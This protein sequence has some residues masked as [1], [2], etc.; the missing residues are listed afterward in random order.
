MTA[1]LWAALAVLVLIASP[2]W[3]GDLWV[4]LTKDTAIA[5]TTLTTPTE[6]KRRVLMRVDDAVVLIEYDCT[7]KT[8]TIL[9]IMRPGQDVYVPENVETRPIKNGT[10][11]DKVSAWAC[12]AL[13]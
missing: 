1:R 9:Y 4:Q 8:S 10:I 3:A 5:P 7:A 6:H 2:T 13:T 11:N 12:K